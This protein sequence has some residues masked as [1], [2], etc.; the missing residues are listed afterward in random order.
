MRDQ[1]FI[2]LGKLYFKSNSLHIEKGRSLPSSILENVNVIVNQELINLAIFKAHKV[3]RHGH[4]K[5]V[6]IIRYRN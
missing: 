6:I 1:L 5:N 4:T 2:E 3:V